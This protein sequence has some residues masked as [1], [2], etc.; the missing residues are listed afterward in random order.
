ML[1]IFCGISLVE[2]W[3]LAIYVADR[4]EPKVNG[5]RPSLFHCYYGSRLHSTA[6]AA[7]LLMLCDST[8]FSGDWAHRTIAAVITREVDRGKKSLA[9]EGFFGSGVAWGGGRLLHFDK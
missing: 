1:W 2:E 8:N 7:I 5:S 9:Y 6:A 3:T 4:A